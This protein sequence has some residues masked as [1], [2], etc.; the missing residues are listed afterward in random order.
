[1][2]EGEQKEYIEWPKTSLSI[3]NSQLLSNLHEIWLKIFISRVLYVARISVGLD[4]NCGFFTNGQVLSHSTFFAHPL[5]FKIWYI[6]I[7]FTGILL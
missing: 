5:I 1:M 6:G 7:Y 3:K 2:L 4:Q